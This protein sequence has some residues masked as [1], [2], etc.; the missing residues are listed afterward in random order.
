MLIP[1]VLFV[2]YMSEFISSFRSL[3]AGSPVFAL[4]MLFL[5][6]I[7]GKSLLFLCI[8]L[9]GMLGLSSMYDVCENSVGSVYVGGYGGLS[10]SGLCVFCK[11]CPVSFLVV[12]E[13]LSFCCS[14]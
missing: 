12:G 3:R 2:F 11:L 1:Y 6:V 9:F 8:L 10:E 7:S 5:C 13:C 14:M 4:F